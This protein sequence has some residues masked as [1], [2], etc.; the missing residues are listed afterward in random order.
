[1]K[2]FI[3]Y[4]VLVLLEVWQTDCFYLKATPGGVLLNSSG[5]EVSPS[6]LLSAPSQ[7]DL[8]NRIRPLIMPQFQIEDS[9]KV[10]EQHN[11]KE[12][13]RRWILLYIRIIFN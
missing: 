5:E 7:K 3:T 10:R 9:G 6:D 12:R 11:Q 8:H 2:H 1:M 13:R 4:R